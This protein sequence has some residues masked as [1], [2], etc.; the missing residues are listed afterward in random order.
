MGAR[1]KSLQTTS[2]SC[3][4][5]RDKLTMEQ[6]KEL[7][8][9]RVTRRITRHLRYH[10]ESYG[11]LNSILLFVLD[12]IWRAF[13]GINLRD[14]GADMALLAVSSLLTVPRFPFVSV[15][16][17]AFMIPWGACLWFI[18]PRC[19]LRFYLLGIVDIRLILSWLVGLSAF[20]F[21]ICFMIVIIS[22]WR[23]KSQGF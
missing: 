21:S 8:P 13:L 4:E 12:C 17:L 23:E 2:R 3:Y 6:T 11:I 7:W 1:P 5:G 14:V 19:S 16:I 10:P 18:S 9:I 22:E 15:L 20:V